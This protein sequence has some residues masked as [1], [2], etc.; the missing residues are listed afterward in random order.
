VTRT[1]RHRYS[2]DCSA[3][4]SLLC[5]PSMKTKTAL[6]LIGVLI[7][8]LSIA[9]TLRAQ[10]AVNSGYHVYP[11]PPP[12]TPEN[13]PT[14]SSNPQA[15][16][17]NQAIAKLVK[18]G[19]GE[20]VIIVMI[21]SQ[22]GKY[23]VAADDVLSLKEQR[24]PDKVI[25]AMLAKGSPAPSPAPSLLSAQ[26]A[27][28][29]APTVSAGPATQA[30][31]RGALEIGVYFR[32]HDGVLAE[33]KPEVVNWQTGGVLKHLGT[34]GFVKG[35]VNGRI[36][37]AHSP[38]ELTMPA[39]LVVYVPDGVAITEYQLINLHEHS[40]AREFR[41]VTGGVFHVS[42]GSTRDEIDFEGRKTAPRTYSIALDKVK[43]GEYGLLPPGL[44]SASESSSTLGKMYTFRIGQ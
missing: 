10:G 7:V 20:D 9:T 27:H 11:P 39:E 24:V 2:F 15:A 30:R 16:L 4:A 3:V 43:A 12:P 33:L 44:E 37:R 6:L 1:T 40:E 21:N 17:D 31:D 25:L 29:D 32:Q 18:A 28:I 34:I 26:P 36:N 42:G 22:P 5:F 8:P 35:D 13:P 41:T 19:L 14:L 38:N 23:A